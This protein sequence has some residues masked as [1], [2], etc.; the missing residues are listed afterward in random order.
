MRVKLMYMTTYNKLVRDRIPEI[1]KSRGGVP[2]VRV[3][4]GQE[5]KT[6][7]AA[8]L[9]EEA[10]EFQGEPSLEEL[11]DVMEVVDAALDA[12][13]WTHK[14]LAL[15]QEKKRRERGGFSERIFLIES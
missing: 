10:V 4:D 6:S 1:I 9:I 14:E 7:I 13:G 11:A 3:L 12:C 8:K 5:Y 2:I 15:V